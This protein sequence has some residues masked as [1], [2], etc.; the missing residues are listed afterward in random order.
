ML[1][2]NT[3]KKTTLCII[4]AYLIFFRRILYPVHFTW[5]NF[6]HGWLL[7][8]MS[9]SLTEQFHE[10]TPLFIAELVHT[11]HRGHSAWQDI[12]NC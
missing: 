7:F 5:L 9:P 4:L 11:N 12:S 3:T 2:N 1:N 6:N 10:T 8:I